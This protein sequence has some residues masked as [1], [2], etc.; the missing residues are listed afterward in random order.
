MEEG[1]TQENEITK[2]REYKSLGRFISIHKESQVLKSP[3]LLLLVYKKI[4][5]DKNMRK[6][7][8]HSLDTK[9]IDSADFKMFSIQL[10]H[11]LF[12]RHSFEY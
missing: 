6:Y 2:W 9:D 4:L 11:R 10:F 12:I 8:M 3:V 5:L 7:T 1:M